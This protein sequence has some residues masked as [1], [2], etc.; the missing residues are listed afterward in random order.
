MAQ[1]ETKLCHYRILHDSDRTAKG[2]QR[3]LYTDNACL[4][5][6]ELPYLQNAKREHCLAL[7]R[8][9]TYAYAWLTQDLI[10][11]TDKREK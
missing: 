5:P 10:G 8:S 6:T 3:C 7:H 2:A 1:V 9:K 11:E 4:S